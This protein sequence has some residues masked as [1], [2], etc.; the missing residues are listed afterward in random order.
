MLLEWNDLDGA[1]QHGQ[2]ALELARQDKSVIDRFAS[3]EVFLARLKL[4]QGDAAGATSMLARVE[5]SVRQ[6]N[7]VHRR[8]EVAAAR[9][10]ALIQEG[11]L[12]AAADLAEKHKLPLS[13]ARIHLAQGDA[14]SALAVLGPYRQYVKAKAWA[15][16]VLKVTILEAIAY[17]LLGQND[18]AVR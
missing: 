6:H 2:Q 10:L 8:Q 18:E 16:E 12:A 9:L 17:H 1:E 13:E 3:C 14:V 7:F 5:Q 11:D 4:A 15:D